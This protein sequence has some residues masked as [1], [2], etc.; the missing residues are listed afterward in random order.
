MTR[1]CW[2]VG[3]GSLIGED[4]SPY[5]RQLQTLIERFKKGLLN[6][7]I[8]H[9]FYK[10]KDY[11]QKQQR[12]KQL[13]TSQTGEQLIK[14]FDQT[15]ALSYNRLM[16]AH[17]QTTNAKL[18][19]LLTKS[20]EQ[21]YV[22]PTLNERSI[23]NATPINV[24][25]D[26]E[27]LLSLGP[28][29]AL[30]T[31]NIKP[32]QLYH[33][34]ADIESILTTHQDKQVQ[35]KN[36]CAIVN[37]IQNYITRNNKCQYKTPLL[38]FCE[39]ATKSLKTFIHE[40][41]NTYVV[42][43]D[44]G[45]RM[46][47]MQADEY[48]RKRLQLLN[49]S[50]YIV[51][52][53]DPT[54]VYQTKNNSFVTR[55]LNL[56]LIDKKMAKHLHSSSAMCPSIYGQPKAHK[57]DLPLRPV[58][59]NTTTP[60]YNLSKMI[61]NIL[62]QSIH[63]NYTITDSFEFVEYINNIILPS[64]YVLVSF[65]VISLFTNIPKD[66]VIHD[67]IMQWDQ[68]S[69]H[70][71]INLDLFLEIVEFCIN[72]SYFRFR[73]KYYQQTFGTAMGSP[74]SPILAE[75]VIENLINTVKKD[76]TFNTPILKKYVDDF[77]LAL[78]K[79]E[80]QNTLQKF[81][82]YNPHIQFTLEEE[83]DNKLPFLD[84]L[85]IRQNNQTIST[86]WYSKPI[87]SGRLLNYHSFHPMLMKMNVA[88][89]FIERVTKLDTTQTM[90]QQKHTIFQYLRQNNYPASLI[91]RLINKIRKKSSSTTTPK[92]NSQ[93][94]SSLNENLPA[95]PDI[96]TQPTIASCSSTDQ[97]NTIYRS[98][99]HINQLTTAISTYLK[100]DYPFIKLAP[101]T[102][103]TTNKYL[104]PIKDPVPT[105][106]QARVIY[107]IPCNTCDKCYIGMTSNQLKTDLDT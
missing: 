87:S 34:L 104:P 62:K 27:V 86:K 21:Q 26:V 101:K 55:L 16:R 45:K 48:D 59:P 95:N 66:L 19:K 53:K 81:N 65:D 33:L 32:C 6:I 100:K 46:V 68:I 79:S 7:E 91:N 47:I 97:R 71:N 31:Q 64:D 75:L 15:Q 10:I 63:S 80:V 76:L 23:L 84:T 43:S 82:S 44:K 9:T 67:I 54:A 98:I 61:A 1:A 105:L 102:I 37:Q 78:P 107:S 14:S 69:K 39:N 24:P 77:I 38:K 11:K 51:L 89:N 106:Q 3:T 88:T 50:T 73:D 90:D 22:I 28:K 96:P 49:S 60:T 56:K 83:S 29:F 18:T 40:H 72:S 42:E 52:S 41:K 70:T 85:V 25:H 5:I 94:I 8:K 103:H 20:I 93:I 4:R 99:P 2:S 30:P 74:L 92:T 57:P 35:D 12:I 58:V 17:K 36:R 13:V